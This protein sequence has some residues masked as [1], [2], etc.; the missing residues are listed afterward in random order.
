MK[1]SNSILGAAVLVSCFTILSK[2]LGFGR[3]ALI[4]AYYGATAETDAFFFAHG[5]PS[6]LF[7]AVGNSISFALTSLYVKRLTEEGE[8]A[9][10]RFA[11]RMLAAGAL[12]GLALGLIGVLLSPILVPILAPGFVGAQKA[13]AI[14]LTRLIM[15]AFVFNV[16]QYM[17]CAVLNS[18]KHFVGAQFS[19]LFYNLV[20]ITAT[21]ALGTRQSMDLLM[22]SVIGGM[23]LQ[24]VMLAVCYRR[25]ARFTPALN[26]FHRDTALLLKLSL[27][28]LLGNSVVQLNNIVDKALGSLLPIGSL[29]ALNYAHNLTD[30]VTGTVIISLSTVLYPTLAED[31]ARVDTNSFSKTLERSMN[32]LTAFMVPVTCIT[33]LDAAEIVRTV[34]ARGSFD[35][36]AVSYTALALACYAPVFIFSGARELLGRAFFSV[37]DTKTPM[38]NSAIGVACNAVFSLAF[39]RRLGIAGIALGTTVAA[40][41]IAVLMLIQAQK[42]LSFRLRSL[43][44]ALMR[45]LLAGGVLV[46]GLLLFR[47]YFVISTPFF[48][49]AA[50]TAA[51][52]ALYGAALTAFGGHELRDVFILLRKKG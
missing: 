9:G 50:D 10:D 6:M 22:L 52:F 15:A 19:A 46:A 20:I 26:P 8:D 12:I 4:A 38:V 11:S 49:F 34:Y 16:L 30:I 45:Q 33:V 47:R 29:S 41:V 3:E 37:Q 40:F 5:M 32:G 35:H 42:R 44:T 39:Y 17:L 2:L 24:V 14:Y 48:R 43:L 28:I 36:T 25:C 27:P 51:G 21:L 7:P 18:K 1:K 13:L 31:A 23:A